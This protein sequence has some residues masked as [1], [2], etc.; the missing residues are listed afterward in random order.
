M[1]QFCHNKYVWNIICN[2]W[3]T[4]SVSRHSHFM[5]QS[6]DISADKSLPSIFLY[7]W[8]G[9]LTYRMLLHAQ[10]QLLLVSEISRLL[11]LFCLFSLKFC[12]IYSKPCC[13]WS[14]FQVFSGSSL[15]PT[16]Y[17]AWTRMLVL[18]Y[19][20]PRWM[21]VQ[22]IVPFLNSPLL[23]MYSFL[24]LLCPSLYKL[25]NDLDSSLRFWRT[26]LSL[27]QFNL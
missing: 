27:F 9:L 4:E 11:L 13:S 23:I 6:W 20:M 7:S 5:D 24:S 16:P 3:S 10:G 19:N 8:K 12:L 14:Q 21:I 2:F 26:T 1:F 18:S 25:C 15:S 22:F 17:Y